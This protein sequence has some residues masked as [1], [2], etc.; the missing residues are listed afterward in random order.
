MSSH[1]P[2]AII[3]LDLDGTCVEHDPTHA[4]FSEMVA[5]QINAAVRHGAAWCTN[6]GRNA[7]NQHGMIQACRA[8]SVPPFA[9]LANECYI[10]DVHPV[11]CAMRPRQPYNNLSKQKALD[12]IPR[13]KEVL[14]QHLAALEA[15]FAV[16]EYFPSTEFV[17]WLLDET[18][19]PVVFARRVRTLLA[20]M[21]DTQVLRNG[22]WVV[23][24]HA[25]FGKGKVLTEAAR[26]LGVPRERI[27]AIGDWHND[28]DMLDGRCTGYVGCP[29]D[30]DAEVRAVVRH[31]GGWIADEP[32][33]AGTCTLLRRF[34]NE[35]LV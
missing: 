20:P 11:T 19:D 24:S 29:A 18:A 15:D 12:M 25:E 7:H 26:G 4:W 35:L 13:V 2:S 27:L 1:P 6:S 30:A 21:G 3:C 31:A 14:G 33:P 32:G 16:A 28:L 22:Q 17:G 8:L 9:I 23:I 10:Y 5:A 34:V